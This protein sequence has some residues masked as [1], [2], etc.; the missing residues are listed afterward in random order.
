MKELRNYEIRQSRIT[1]DNVIRSLCGAMDQ[2]E[3]GEVWLMIS[4]KPRVKVPDELDCLWRE[5]DGCG[6]DLLV[7]KIL[8]DDGNLNAA[9]VGLVDHV[10]RELQ[11][12]VTV[13]LAGI[14][15]LYVSYHPTALEARPS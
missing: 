3:N 11:N 10:N 4:T 14:D 1:K 12:E 15:Q 13:P 7:K 5:D 2:A 8:V 9:I 6:F